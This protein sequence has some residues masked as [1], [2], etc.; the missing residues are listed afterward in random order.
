MAVIDVDAPSAE[1]VGAKV[2]GPFYAIDVRDPHALRMAVDEAADA[3]GGLDTIFNNAGVGSM[4]RLH[5]YEPDEFGR[6]V[7]VNLLGV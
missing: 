7:D 3:L 2:D 6:V 5:E 1:A 4:S